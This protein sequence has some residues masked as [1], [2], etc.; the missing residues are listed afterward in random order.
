MRQTG[1]SDN[2]AGLGSARPMKKNMFLP[3]EGEGR[4]LSSEALAKE[5]EGENSGSGF[6]YLLPEEPGE[7]FGQRG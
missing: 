6:F 1:T 7:G 3:L 5:G 2:H 4:G